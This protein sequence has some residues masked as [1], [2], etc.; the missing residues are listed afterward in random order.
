MKKWAFC[1]PCEWTHR[2]FSLDELMSF[3]GSAIFMMRFI[4]NNL[5]HHVSCCVALQQWVIHRH[6]HAL[7][8]GRTDNN[9]TYY[10]KTMTKNTLGFM[11]PPLREKNCKNSHL[12]IWVMA[13][14][15]KLFLTFVVLHFGNRSVRPEGRN[16]NCLVCRD[17]VV[18]QSAC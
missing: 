8:T 9:C 12:F 10:Y 14:T 6:I 5:E 15:A 1:C 11:S 17:A 4:L 3:S 13:A 16:W 7:N 2:C 18:N